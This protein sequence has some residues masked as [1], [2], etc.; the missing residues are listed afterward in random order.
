MQSHN[1]DNFDPA[2][3]L[4][5]WRNAGGGWAGSAI[6]LPPQHRRKLRAML[7]ELGP[8]DIRAVAEHLGAQVAA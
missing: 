6:L 7:D 3:W 1:P 5:R 4:A 8:D 2:A